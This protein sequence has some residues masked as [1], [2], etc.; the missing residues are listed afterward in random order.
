MHFVVSEKGPKWV[1]LLNVKQS[2]T[3]GCFEVIKMVLLVPKGKKK[4]NKNEINKHLIRVQPFSAL[5]S[6]MNH[7]YIYFLAVVGEYQMLLQQIPQIN[8]RGS[9]VPYFPKTL[10]ESKI[11]MPTHTEVLQQT[12]HCTN[13]LV[14]LL[15]SSLAR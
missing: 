3:D 8:L 6:W 7:G 11:P 4:S 15:V 13:T 9:S 5:R 2:K 14:R 10:S 1:C 12:P